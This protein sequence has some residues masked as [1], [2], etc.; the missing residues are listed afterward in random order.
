[1]DCDFLIVGAGMAGASAGYELAHRGS[2]ILLERESQPGYHTTGRSAAMFIESYG[3]AT[4]RAITSASR[5][6]FV[7]PPEGFSEAALLSPRG[8]LLLARKDQMAALEHEYAEVSRDAPNLRQLDKKETLALF[9][10]VNPDYVEAGLLDP[11]A[12]DMDVHAIHQGFL[13][14]LR[15]RGGEL[16]TSAEVTSAER[17]GGRWH[18]RTP[19]GDFAAPVL[20]NAA[21]AWADVLAA[22]AGAKP[23]GL[24]PKRRTAFIFDAPPG[25]RLDGCPLAADVEEQFYFKPEAGKLLGSPADE[26]PVE[27]QDVQPEELDIAIAA[28]RIEKA[29]TFK[30][31]RISRRWA[32]LRSFVA[33]KTLV[34]GFAPDAE[35]FFW[36]AGQG[37]YGI[38]TSPAM[39]RITAALA[40]GA[41]LPP[42]VAA[43]GVTE[44]QLGP[45]RCW[46]ADDR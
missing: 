34:A 11:D 24:V 21:G 43:R 23:V 44:A 26:T 7:G 4:V 38:Q 5:A 10:L 39:G 27:P 18:V 46:E 33:D 42:D 28:D 15:A 45:A 17:K 36:L 2:V 30:I 35:G 3:N 41:S 8:V 31:A 6:F 20:V 1:M 16:V 9:P 22:R 40:S 14:G 25:S 19:A 13:R 12:M 29:V 32:G 37:G